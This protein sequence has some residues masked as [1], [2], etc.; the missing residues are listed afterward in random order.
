MIVACRICCTLNTPWHVVRL[1]SRV[2]KR[3][4]LF[5]PLL[6][7]A[8]VF[9]YILIYLV[10]IPKKFHCL[11]KKDFKLKPWKITILIA[12]FYLNLSCQPIHRLNSINF[13]FWIKLEICSFSPQYSFYIISWNRT[14]LHS[15]QIQLHTY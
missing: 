10:K 8:S 14:C 12:I 9:K 4:S 7:S 6:L 15:L 1:V 11:R 5:F 3:F 2:N 13:K